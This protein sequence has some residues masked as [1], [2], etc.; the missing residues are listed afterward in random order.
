MSV[1]AVV[2]AAG[3]G[4]RF[5]GAKQFALVDGES[6]AAR[7]VKACRSV[8]DRVVLVVPEGYD[9]TGEGA[10]V[11]VSGGSSRADSVRCGLAQCEDADVV[12]VHD[13]ARPN[14]SPALFASVIAAIEDGADAAIPGLVLTDTVKRVTL[15]GD[16]TV[17]AETLTREE[18]VGVQTPQAF[19]RDVLVRAHASGDEATDDAG[20]VEAIGAVVVVVPGESTNVKIT[21]PGDLEA[22]ARRA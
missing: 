5:G 12:I 1:A 18:L 2:V 8:A 4:T 11:V 21:Q 17:V 7:S 3:R 15:K 20:L 9:G 6:V 22:L 13:A 16:V 19:R 10:D 14:A